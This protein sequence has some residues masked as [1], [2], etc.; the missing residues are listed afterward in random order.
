M[1]EFSYYASE[2]LGFLTVFI[3]AVYFLLGF[4]DLVFDMFFWLRVVRR[5]FDRHKFPR[6][7]VEKLRSKTEQRIAIMIPCW[8]EYPVVE[9]MLEFA[10]STIEYRRY[11]IFVGVYPNDERTVAAAQAAAARHPQVK[12]VINPTPGPTTKAQNLNA[13]FAEIERTEGNEPYQIMVLHDTE[14][15]IHPLSLKMYNYLMPQRQMIQLPV[16]PLERPPLEWTSWTY[17]DEFAENH[18]KDM[19]VREAMGSFVPSAGVGCAFSRPALEIISVTAEDVFPSDT[20]TEDYQTGLR[21]KLR[22]LSTI[23]VSQ[24]LTVRGVSATQRPPRTLRPERTSPTTSMLPCIKKRAGS[25]EFVLRRGRRPAGSAI[26]PCG[27][28]SIA[29]ARVLRATCSRSSD[30]PSCSA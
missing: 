8:H 19:I 22:G 25:L 29:T 23:F 26:L 16:L 13:I 17:A 5:A 18:Q 2:I 10:A 12:V 3:A 30:T 28:R 6:L 21:L 11:D 24:R 4:D 1:V 15:V 9:R 20:L 14:D 7:T 27:T